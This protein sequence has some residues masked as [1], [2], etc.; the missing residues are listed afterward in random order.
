MPLPD[1]TQTS[2]KT[3]GD[4]DN[5]ATGKLPEWLTHEHTEK[6]TDEWLTYE[7]ARWFADC[8]KDTKSHSPGT[9]GASVS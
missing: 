2:G 3:I 5:E 9:A 1:G 6:I 8:N 7:K 4:K